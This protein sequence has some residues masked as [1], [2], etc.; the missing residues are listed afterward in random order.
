ME[1]LKPVAR[2][3]LETFAAIEGAASELLTKR[4]LSLQSLAVVNEATAEAVAAQMRDRNRARSSNLQELRR[5]PA[6]AR[7]V[8]ADEDDKRETI[9]IAPN[10]EVSLPGLKLCSYLA[11]RAIRPA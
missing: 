1:H 5:K 11:P 4:G 9:Y 7:L 2:E 3:A 6:I 8:I 10:A